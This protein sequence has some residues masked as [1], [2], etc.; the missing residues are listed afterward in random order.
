MF[1]R[2]DMDSFVQNLTEVGKGDVDQVGGKAANIGELFKVESINVPEG[3]CVNTSAF[4]R[5]ISDASIKKLLDALSVA[6]VEDRHKI[7]ELCGK[8][9]ALIEGTTIPDDIRKEIIAHLS[10]QGDHSVF[11]VR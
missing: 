4:K 5:I 2:L 11:A 8:I 3:F 6:G 9:R 1:G 7:T 10:A